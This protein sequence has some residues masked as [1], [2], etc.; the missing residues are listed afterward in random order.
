ML[1]GT[2]T[3]STKK[4]SKAEQSKADQKY[5]VGSALKSLFE[6]KYGYGIP[7]SLYIE[8]TTSLFSTLVKKKQIIK[9]WSKDEDPETRKTFDTSLWI[10]SIRDRDMQG[11]VE[12]YFDAKI[13]S[14]D[15]ISQETK[16]KLEVIFR[17]K[18]FL[19]KLQKTREILP[20]N[21]LE[22]NEGEAYDLITQHLMNKMREQS[23]KKPVITRIPPDSSEI[24]FIRN[25]REF[26]QFA[27][28]Y[29][30]GL[31]ENGPGEE[32]FEEQ[33]IYNHC[34]YLIQSINVKVKSRARATKS[35]KQLTMNF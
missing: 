32:N 7:K 8:F 33:I 22:T 3:A 30:K 18:T 17:S 10:S 1:A 11:I 25:Q 34:I 9:F 15:E 23:G 6:S 35:S 28:Q 4:L 26:G 12:K 27:S 5:R 29:I 24:F 13:K 14:R 2:E 16:N 31:L 20:V 19:A 21:D